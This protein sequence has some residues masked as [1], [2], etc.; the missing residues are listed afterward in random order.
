MLVEQATFVAT[1]C[2]GNGPTQ[3]LQLNKHN[4]SKYFS[5]HS[6]VHR[7]KWQLS[8]TFLYQLSRCQNEPAGFYSCL[9]PVTQTRYIRFPTSCMM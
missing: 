3:H 9:L 7:I 2:E 4:L 1:P 5:E 6:K 8:L